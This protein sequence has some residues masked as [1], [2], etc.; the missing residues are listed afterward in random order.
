MELETHEL[1]K[2]LAELSSKK[3]I[4]L[5]KA[6]IDAGTFLCAFGRN[7]KEVNDMR[8]LS[9]IMHQYLEFFIDNILTSKFEHPE[10]IDKYYYY[11]GFYQK[12]ILLGAFG[13]YEGSSG[14]KLRSNIKIMNEIRNHYAHHMDISLG[15]AIPEKIKH[16]IDAMHNFGQMKC[17]DEDGI[18]SKYKSLCIMTFLELSNLY[19][20]GMNKA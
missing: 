7:L 11:F 13:I 2:K 3:R 12:C 6:L 19:L 14:E 16:K 4:E 5:S 1:S 9:I 15:D 8:F 20:D 18:S 10:I 17:K